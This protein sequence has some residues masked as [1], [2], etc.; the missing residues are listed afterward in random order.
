MKLNHKVMELAEYL[1]NLLEHKDLLACFGILIVLAFAT[2][3]TTSHL[4]LATHESQQTEEQ[5]ATMTSYLNTWRQKSE[6]IN[7][8]TMRPVKSDQIDE[9]QMAVLMNIQS[10]KLNLTSMKE[11]G[12]KNEKDGKSFDMEFIGD[13]PQVIDCLEHFNVKDALIGIKDLGMEMQDEKMRVRLTY[14]IYTK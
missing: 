12:D 6:R 10:H 14:K 7:H 9:V 13:Y 3:F 4:L 11:S 8:A 2:S 1:P 5:I